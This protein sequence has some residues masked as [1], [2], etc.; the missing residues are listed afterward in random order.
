MNPREHLPAA[1][2][3]DRRKA[4]RQPE[5]GSPFAGVLSMLKRRSAAIIG[6]SRPKCCI[7]SVMVLVDRSVPVDGLL[8]ELDVDAGLFRPASVYILDRTGAEVVL[9]F[10]EREVRGSVRGVSTRGYDIAF[11]SPLPTGFVSDLIRDFG[12]AD[13]ALGQIR[14]G[15]A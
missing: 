6:A 10:A 3:S 7:V 2:V 8:T 5:S 1:R 4:P 15:K 13:G 9:R 14:P 11:A 12:M